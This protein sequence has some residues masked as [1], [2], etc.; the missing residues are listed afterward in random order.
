MEMPK[1][2]IVVDKWILDLD[3][4]PEAIYKVR[5]LLATTLDQ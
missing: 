2:N 3:Q 1:Y 5:Y 4:D